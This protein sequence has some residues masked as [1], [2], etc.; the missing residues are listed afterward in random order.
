MRFPNPCLVAGL[1]MA[2]G[3]G[4]QAEPAAPAPEAKA[5]AVADVK[6]LLR[7]PPGRGQ[8]ALALG[9][10]GETLV[11][12][13]CRRACDWAHAVSLQISPRAVN[14][15]AKLPS[16]LIGDGRRATVLK[17][18]SEGTWA[19]VLVATDEAAPRVLFDAATPGDTPPPGAL[20]EQVVITAGEKQTE[21]VVGKLDPALQLCGRSTL[22]EPRVLLADDLKLHRVKYQRLSSAERDSA[23]K[24]VA[25]AREPQAPLVRF[26]SVSASSGAESAVNAVDNDPSTHWTETRSGTGGGEFL[27]LRVP[28]SIPIVALNFT[29]P[30]MTDPAL[31]PSKVWVVTD[32]NVYG[33]SFELQGGTF[34][35]NSYQVHLPAPLH[36]RC[37]AVALDTAHDLPSK[38]DGGAHVGISEVSA[39]AA[40][41]QDELVRWVEK[42]SGPEAEAAPAQAALS[43]LGDLALV[44]LGERFSQLNHLGQ[45]RVLDILDSKDCASAAELYL[46][47][48][49]GKL[50][51]RALR[52][53]QVCGARAAPKLSA[54][55]E[56]DLSVA[57]AT[58]ELLS[59]LDPARAVRALTPHLRSP[60]RDARL[61]LRSAIAAA[62]QSGKADHAVAELLQ[63]NMP[64]FAAIDLLRAGQGSLQ[65]FDSSASAQVLRLLGGKPSFRSR[66]L[67]LGPAAELASKH[68]Q[69]EQFVRTTL[70]HDPQFGIRARAA[71]LAP[72]APR[73]T[74]DLVRA[75]RDEHVRVRLAAVQR[76]GKNQVVAAQPVLLEL[77][78]SDP[79]PLVRSEA[80]RALAGF[81]SAARTDEALANAAENDPSAHVRRPALVA[82]G[83]RNAQQHL[84]LVRDRFEHDENLHVRAAAAEAL[85]AMC[86]YGSVDELTR[87]AAGVAQLTASPQERVIGRS[88]LNAL[89]RLRP[90]DLKKRLALF[91]GKDVPRA[92]IALARAAEQHP[93]PCQG[94]RLK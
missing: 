26:E 3:F 68:P 11:A 92:A 22:L 39:T 28:E 89:G 19:T 64:R 53:L 70:A 20:S 43:A 50:E 5:V 32:K 80:V 41:A 76:L 56:A 77:L 78:E 67:L 2:T 65:R 9:Q 8:P 36:T 62:I 83:R 37:L 54:A 25:L 55:A 33:V 48:I 1:V 88:A 46:M 15:M 29:L 30:R 23:P 31:M 63:G 51:G 86:D 7:G 18:E 27:V 49:G 81:P 74:K 45:T 90:V 58:A 93:S 35:E 44:A 6:E 79:W 69:I 75:A 84:Q 57:V 52:T 34:R 47:A 72:A 10:V 16:Y 17:L 61:A 12:A 91:S 60:R 21:I 24:I 94:G 42:L 38:V 85:G 4:A 71:E 14:G 40:L 66:Y 59:R 13:N 82:L 87:Y 73:F